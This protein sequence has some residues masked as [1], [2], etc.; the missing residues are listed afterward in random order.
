MKIDYGCSLRRKM[1]AFCKIMIK[2]QRIS[3]PINQ[4][5]IMQRWNLLWLS[6]SRSTWGIWPTM[7][8]SCIYEHWTFFQFK[9]W[10]D[11]V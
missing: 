4:P 3:P 8:V 6:E 10:N 5:L 9:N 2:H 1:Q 11:L 7:R